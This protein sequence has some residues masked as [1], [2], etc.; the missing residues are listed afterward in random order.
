M[1]AMGARPGSQINYEQFRQAHMKQ[2]SSNLPAGPTRDDTSSGRP[3]T[4]SDGTV[5]ASLMSTQGNVIM[6]ELS[7]DMTTDVLGNDGRI[8]LGS[9]GAGLGPAQGNTATGSRYG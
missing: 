9:G 1:A 6:P 2:Q 8:K 4:G 3:G 7:E 5:P